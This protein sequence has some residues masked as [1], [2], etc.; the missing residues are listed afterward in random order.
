[1]L[2]KQWGPFV[3]GSKYRDMQGEEIFVEKSDIEYMDSGRRYVFYIRK[4]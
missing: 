2:D 4:H 1:M 3:Q